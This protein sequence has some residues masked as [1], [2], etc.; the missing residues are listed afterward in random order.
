MRCFRSP[1][2]PSPSRL[3][4]IMVTRMAKRSRS[5]LLASLVF[6]AASRFPPSTAWATFLFSDEAVKLGIIR[7][8]NDCRFC[9][10]ANASAEHMAQRD[11]SHLAKLQ[12]AGFLFDTQKVGARDCEHCHEQR[13]ADGQHLI[14]QKIWE[15]K[16]NA[17]ARWMQSFQAA[18]D[19]QRRLDPRPMGD[20]RWKD[21]EV[22]TVLEA[23]KSSYKR[24]DDASA[25]AEYLGFC[26]P[27]GE[28]EVRARAGEKG[29]G[30]ARIELSQR[31]R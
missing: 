31:L 28:R 10:G 19:A 6:L 27:L 29:D 23:F 24:Q 7:S 18:R 2:G 22:R 14:P 25:D 4:E 9:H 5:V 11:E 12:A 26:D 15:I 21:Q 17:R 3:S 30:Q 16:C 13:G 20:V 1:W 8:R